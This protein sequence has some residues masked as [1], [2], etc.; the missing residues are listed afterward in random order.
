VVGHELEGMHGPAIAAGEEYPQGRVPAHLGGVGEDGAAPA[1]AYGP[2]PDDLR[3]VCLFGH[4]DPCHEGQCPLSGRGIAG[5]HGMG[6]E[7][8]FHG[9]PA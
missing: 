5:G 9:A 4:D 6:G 8:Y 3:L 2:G 1:A 7:D